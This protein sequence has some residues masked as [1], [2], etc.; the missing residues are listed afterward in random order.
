MTRATKALREYIWRYTTDQNAV[1]Q[2][3]ALGFP[4]ALI[5]TPEYALENIVILKNAPICSESVL[6]S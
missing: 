4:D 6:V 1:L 2:A 5:S 3:H